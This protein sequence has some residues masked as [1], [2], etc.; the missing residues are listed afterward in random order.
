M[1][2][3]SGRLLGR[4]VIGLGNRASRANEFLLILGS[5]AHLVLYHFW[6]ARRGDDERKDVRRSLMHAR[7]IGATKL[8]IGA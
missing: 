3:H 8:R 4:T 7:R 6:T 2:C 1:A 5:A